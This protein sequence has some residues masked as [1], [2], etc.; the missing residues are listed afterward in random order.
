M[1][2]TFLFEFGA[3]L[4]V[5][6]RYKMETLTRLIMAMLLALGTFQLAEYM[7]CGGLGLHTTE[8]SR[9]GYISITLLPAFGVHLLAT[10]AGK[11]VPWLIYSAYASMILFALYFALTPGVINDHEC[12]PNYA[13]FS[14]DQMSTMLYA[15]YYYG[16]LVVTVIL[17][18]LWSRKNK[19][20]L[21]L[22]A[23]S[24]GYLLFMVPTVTITL[25]HPST[26]SGIPSIMCGFAVLLAIVFVTVVLPNSRAKIRKK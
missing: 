9:L 19:S 18:L 16:W 17:A 2:L 24:V 7:I 10:I 12:R 11:K 25:I 21:A 8:W 22:R 20:A 23:M 3:A 26:T 4:Y 13:V 6:W 1:L 14:L 15:I 5:L